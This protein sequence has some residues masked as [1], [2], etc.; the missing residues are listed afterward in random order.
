MILLCVLPLIVMLIARIA[1]R[2]GWMIAIGGLVALSGA[3]AIGGMWAARPVAGLVIA[4]SENLEI[5]SRGLDPGV[6]R[7]LVLVVV[8]DQR[9]D[10]EL[11]RPRRAVTT[12]GNP[13]LAALMQ[14]SDSLQCEVD[15]RLFDS[16]R[17]GDRIPLHVMRWGLVSFA[18]PDAEPWWNWAPG[19][20]DRLLPR[21]WGAGPSVTTQAQIDSVRTVRDADVYAWGS[22]S[23]NGLAHFPLSQPYDELRLHFVTSRGAQIRV[24]DRVD[25]GSAGVLEPGSAVAI[26]YPAGR[27][28]TARLSIGSRSY[29]WRNTRSYWGDM[30]LVAVVGIVLLALAEAVRRWVGR[31]LRALP[32]NHA[33]RQARSKGS[34]RGG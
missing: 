28:R 5:A 26:S 13:R 22:S 27:P 12:T 30:A 8:E 10:P 34:S 2:T 21:W 15:E 19:R 7:R 6:T 33:D 17:E 23:A 32:G 31:R 16:V 4:K 3:A 14:S 18:R 24:L 29:A 1:S 11:R 9:A 25:A 20:L